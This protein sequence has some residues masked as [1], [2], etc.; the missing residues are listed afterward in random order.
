[1]FLLAGT[2]VLNNIKQS[3]EDIKLAN[4]A[5]HAGGLSRHYQHIKLSAAAV[6]VHAG[7]TCREARAHM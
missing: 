1:M 7:K 6:H 4:L 3:P 2:R 5:L